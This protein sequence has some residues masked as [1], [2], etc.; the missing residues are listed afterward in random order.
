MTNFLDEVLQLTNDVDNIKF[1]SDVRTFNFEIPID[2]QS[3]NNIDNIYMQ[4]IENGEHLKETMLYN[5]LN[6]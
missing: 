2:S 4:D 5:L 1:S 3:E 6:K